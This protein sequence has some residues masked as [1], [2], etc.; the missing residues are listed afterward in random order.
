[1]IEVY[2]K[3]KENKILDV[4]CTGNWEDAYKVIEQYIDINP[5]KVNEVIIKKK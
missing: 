3:S 2:F 4:F 1:M 5:D